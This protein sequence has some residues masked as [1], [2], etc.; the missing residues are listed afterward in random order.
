MGSKSRNL[1][2]QNSGTGS[3]GRRIEP[4][5]RGKPGTNNELLCAPA[6]LHNPALRKRPLLRG[7]A[8]GEARHA[9]A[10]RSPRR[11]RTSRCSSAFGARSVPRRPPHS[12]RRRRCCLL[13]CLRRLPHPRS[14]RRSRSRPRYRPARAPGPGPRAQR[15]PPARSACAAS[16]GKTSSPSWSPRRKH[17][18]QPAV[19]AATEHRFR[20]GRLGWRRL[21][22]TSGA[23]AMG[24]V[25]FLDGGGPPCQC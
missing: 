13:R 4:A 10:A 15:P 1:D 17:R 9:P 8:R 2:V 5:A 21:D 23:G 25:S 12:P 11:W 7:T 14:S 6:R 24:R 3:T 20:S 18:R 19:S 16:P 22:V